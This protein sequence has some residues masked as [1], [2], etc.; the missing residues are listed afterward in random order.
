M[1]TPLAIINLRSTGDVVAAIKYFS[2]K[3]KVGKFLDGLHTGAAVGDSKQL[4]ELLLCGHHNPHG[5]RVARTAVISV[6][7]PHQATRQELED[8]DQ[9]LVRAFWDFSKLLQVPMLGWLHTNTQSRHLHV[10]FVNSTGVHC[11][12]L[13]PAWLRQLQGF[14]WTAALLSG[15]G[16]GRRKALP[17]YPKSKNLVVRDLANLLMDGQGNLRQDRWDDLVKAGQITNFRRRNDG[18]IVSFEWGKRRV[19]VATLKGFIIEQST[20]PG[21][22]NVY[23]NKPCQLGNGQAV[24]RNGQLDLISVTDQNRPAVDG[25]TGP[26]ECGTLPPPAPPKPTAPAAPVFPARLSEKPITSDNEL[27]GTPNLEPTGTSPLSNCGLAGRVRPKR[28][29]QVRPAPRFHRVNRPGIGF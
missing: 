28:R 9:R 29:G 12:D 19:R 25:T 10:L 8:I 6:K 14:A 2:D 22:N 27:G 7:T 21:K 17:T 5:K 26:R 11:L 23:E 18:S 16:R 4:A 20:P 15:R 24:A 13:R 1:N 3:K